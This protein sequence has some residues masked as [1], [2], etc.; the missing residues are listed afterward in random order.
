MKNVTKSFTAKETAQEQ[1]KTFKFFAYWSPPIT[2]VHYRAVKACGYTHLY[3]D[4]KF[5]AELGTATLVKAVKLCG[6]V[7]LKAIIQGGQ[8][9]AEGLEFDKD[10]N[11]YSGI[12]AFDGVNSDEPLT[13]GDLEMLSVS[14]DRFKAKYPDRNFYVNMVGMSGEAWEIYSEKYKTLITDKQIHRH[15]SGDTYP[16]SVKANGIDSG[17]LSYLEC[18]AAFAADTKSELYFF[19]QTMSMGGNINARRPSLEDIRYNSYVILAFGAKGLQNFCYT[20]PGLPPYSGEFRHTDYACLTDAEDGYKKTEIYD[21]A[22]AVIAELKGFENE[23]LSFEWQ[24]IMTVDGAHSKEKNIN[25]DLESTLKEHGRIESITATEDLLVGCFNDG[26]RDAVLL[27]NFRDPRDKQQNRVTLTFKDATGATVYR[28]GKVAAEQITNSVWNAELAPG[29]GIFIVLPATEQTTDSKSRS[30]STQK[31]IAPK[32]V[33]VDSNGKLTFKKS[34]NTKKCTLYVNGI[35]VCEAKNRTDVSAYFNNGWNTYS[36]SCGGAMSK[37]KRFF[38]IAADKS[39]VSVY[40][41]F[42]DF[43]D[44]FKR[45][46]DTY[47]I[48]GTGRA[49]VELI[50]SGYPAGGNGT[51]L[52][53]RTDMKKDKDWSA[54]QI[55]TKPLEDGRDRT[56]ILDVYFMPCAFNVSFRYDAFNPD[57]PSYNVSCTDKTGGW[58]QVVIPLCKV[59]PEHMTRLDRLYMTTGAGVPFG[60]IAYINSYC[61]SEEK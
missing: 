14:L 13:A 7:G 6:K 15:V 42:S 27:V 18:I 58:R 50:T 61:I 38:K 57:C 46:P 17:W 33:F 40:E 1:G 52:R 11:D 16:L 4:G 48:F 12:A 37:E 28:G 25:F 34:A 47:N 49:H 60:T 5:G 31:D 24:G 54:F 59:W 35:S 44:I 39:N 55:L 19:L 3:I 53:L 9:T 30:R 32:L 51:V 29:E 43:S 20:A 21:Y 45:Y 2:E 36:V 23:F 41:D 10:S 56:L 26:N 8:V 22:Q